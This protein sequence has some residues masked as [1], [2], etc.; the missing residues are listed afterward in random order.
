MTNGRAWKALVAVALGAGAVPAPSSASI[1]ADAPP[2]PPVV[3]RLVAQTQSGPSNLMQAELLRPPY[4]GYESRVSVFKRSPAARTS[5]IIAFS[6]SEVEGTHSQTSSFRW[7]LPKG[8]LRM[9]D[10]LK[11][12]SI[13]TGKAMGVNGRIALKLV[14]SRQYVRGT[15]EGC[16]GTIAYRLATLQGSFKFDARDEHFKV[17]RFAR[18]HVVLYRA[19]D[20]R[21]NQP[22]PPTGSSCPPDM[23]LTALDPETG[24]AVGAFRTA[25]GKVDQTVVVSGTSGRAKT[26]HRISVTVAVPEAF[27]ASDDLTSASVDGDVAGPWL[28]GDLSYIAPPP[29]VPVEDADCGPYESTSGLATGDYTARFDSIGPVTPA[30]TGMA[31]TLRRAAP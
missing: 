2:L 26:A 17:M 8:A 27:E 18:T 14:G 23:S 4:K 16:T 1:P 5:L 3:R 12:A 19:H 25:E 13:R 6:R 24:V 22:P 29:A 7:T 31:A 30:S 10:D 9:D 28:S 11:P 20:L 21:C 15:P